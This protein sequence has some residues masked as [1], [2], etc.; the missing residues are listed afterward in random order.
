[1]SEKCDLMNVEG[2]CAQQFK[3]YL[4]VCH[5]STLHEF[6][7]WLSIFFHQSGQRSNNNNKS[8]EHIITLCKR[9]NVRSFYS[10]QSVE[11]FAEIKKNNYFK[12]NLFYLTILHF[13][14]QLRL[15]LID[16]SILYKI[17]SVIMTFFFCFI[18]FF[19]FVFYLFVKIMQ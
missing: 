11:H 6:K 15:F 10:I 14:V 5:D 3:V 7:T 18:R 2:Y 17:I 4:Y 16:K 8:N 19:H 12:I 9:A 13:D 1:M